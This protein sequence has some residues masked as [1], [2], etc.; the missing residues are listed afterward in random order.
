MYCAECNRL[1]FA[2]SFAKDKICFVTLR[3]KNVHPK[4]IL[5]ENKIWIRS[6]AIFFSLYTYDFSLI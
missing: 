6:V 1:A 5:S 3:F 2:S 4:L